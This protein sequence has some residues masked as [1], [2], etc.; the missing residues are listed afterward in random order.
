MKMARIRH[1]KCNGCPDCIGCGRKYEY[2]YTYVCD[3]C[4]HESD[5]KM[6]VDNCGQDICDFCLEVEYEES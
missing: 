1:E 3:E 5:E 2:Y 4:G 6:F